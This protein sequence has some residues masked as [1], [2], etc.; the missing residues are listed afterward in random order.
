MEKLKIAVE[1][2]PQEERFWDDMMN[3]RDAICAKKDYNARL[4]FFQKELAAM[5]EEFRQRIAIKRRLEYAIGHSYEG[6]G[7]FATEGRDPKE[8]YPHFE[9]AVV[10]YQTSDETAG[11]IT[12]YAL[13]QAE[14]CFGAAQFRRQSGLDDSVTQWFAERGHILISTLFGQEVPVMFGGMPDY[15]KQLAS[16]T[17]K[18]VVNIHVVT[19]AD[20]KAYLIKQN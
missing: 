16:E 15:L 10:W 18:N 9:R 4:A 13:R 12:D 3:R 14:S 7:T 19:K 2:I 8:R 5:P 1:F 17:I 11:F 6:L 20:L